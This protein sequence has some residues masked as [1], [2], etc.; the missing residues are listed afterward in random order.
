MYTVQDIQQ[1]Y[2]VTEGTVLIWIRSGQL[3]ALN[4][5]RKPGAKKPRWRVTDA[6]LAA[7]EALRTPTPPTPRTSRPRSAA[8]VEFYS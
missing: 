6:A 5:G 3:K 8:V 2:G 1:R 4:V 7:F